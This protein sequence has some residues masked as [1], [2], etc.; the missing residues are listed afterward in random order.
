MDCP[1]KQDDS[2]VGSNGWGV[3]QLN[4][5]DSGDDV[6]C[7]SGDDMFNMGEYKKTMS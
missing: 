3:D 1:E 5:N 4:L 6:S 7:E 2:N